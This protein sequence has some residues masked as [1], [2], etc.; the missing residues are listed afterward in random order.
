MTYIIVEQDFKKSSWGKEIISGFQNEISSRRVKAEFVKGTELCKSNNRNDFAV[1]IC[2]ENAWLYNTAREAREK[3]YNVIACCSTNYLP[4]PDISCVSCD[5]AGSVEYA[6]RYLQSTGKRNI[7]LY[8]VNPD[9][10]QDYARAQAFE[11]IEFSRK[12]IF[13][14]NASLDDCFN[15]FSVCSENY[16]AVICVND[17]AAVSL[18]KMLKTAG[19]RLPYIV[20][21]SDTT[22][23]KITVPSITSITYDYKSYG[24]ATFGVMELLKKNNTITSVRADIK[25][26]LHPRATTEYFQYNADE[27]THIERL[28]VGKNFYDDPTVKNMIALENLLNCC[29]KTDIMILCDMLKG[30]TVAKI[31]EKRFISESTVKYRRKKYISECG[32][33]CS[34]EFLALISKY[35][36]ADE[37]AKFNK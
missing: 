5:V 29:D 17:Y 27:K 18:L 13:Y 7:A 33:S 26:R 15:E 22:L 32:C 2:A 28:P 12:N 8:A 30:I 10:I 31:A 23:S 35:F 1:L 24:A 3:G 36:T 37:L 19:K 34:E 11:N 21:Y 14:N 25:W 16:N 9:S 20:S 4:H 6:Y